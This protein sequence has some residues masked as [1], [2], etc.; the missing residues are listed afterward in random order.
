MAQGGRRFASLG[1]VGFVDDDSPRLQPERGGVDLVEDEQERLE[2]GDD[3]A[4]RRRLQRRGQ[5]RGLGAFGPG[6]CLDDP[7]DTFELSDILPELFVE[8]S[9]VGNDDDL[10]EDLLVDVVVE[11][12]QAMCEPGDGV[13]LPRPGRVL[14]QVVVPG[15]GAAGVTFDLGDGVPLVVAGEDVP[16]VLVALDEPAEDV[17]P[18][19]AGP[20]RFPQVAGGVP[21]RVVRVALATVVAPVERKEARRGTLELGG[22]GD[23]V[24]VDG[25]VND[26]AAQVGVFHAVAVLAVL[27]HGVLDV[28]T[29]KRVLQFGGGDEDAVEEQADIDGVVVS[30]RVP[31]L[32]GH[33][34][35]VGGVTLGEGLVHARGGLE[36]RELDGDALVFHA[37]AQAGDGASGLDVLRH[38]G[39]ETSL[40]CSWVAAVP[41]DD[42]LPGWNLSRP[43]EGEQFSGVE[44]S[45]QVE[46]L[47]KRLGVP[48]LLEEE[49][50]DLRFEVLLLHA[51]LHH[52]ATSNSPVTAAVMT[53]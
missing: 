1:G 48:T 9:P 28:L 33:G 43:N 44:P 37:V 46:V 2:G 26:G 42:L 18:S 24:G 21:V 17:E 41:L 32:A 34:E 30:G 45:G 53:A 7:L 52:H 23:E 40:R 16:S 5:V 13:R 20:D 47:R 14:D 22:H 31:Q 49:R 6:D 4:G 29:G 38:A 25:E 51:V 50:L 36:V 39:C 3:D 27:R 35:A 12:G 10:V 8:D 11:G 19:V 15:T